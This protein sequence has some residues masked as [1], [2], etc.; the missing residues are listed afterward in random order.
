MKVSFYDDV[1][2]GEEAA[3][4]RYTER[5][6]LNAKGDK[7]LLSIE[8]GPITHKEAESMI[9]MWDNAILKMKELAEI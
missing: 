5:Y 4:G 8:A 1:N 7:T 6:S 3:L 2:A 9:P